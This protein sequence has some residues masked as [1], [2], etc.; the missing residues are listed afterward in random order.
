MPTTLPLARRLGL[1][2]K[3]LRRMVFG[4]AGQGGAGGGWYG[5]LFG[6]A[7]AP[8]SDY[9]YAVQAGDF[10]RNSAVAAC[11]RVIRS[12]VAEP[13]IEVVRD[14]AEGDPNPVA[15]APLVKLLARPNPWYDADVFLGAMFVS[16]I[17]DGNAIALKVRSAAGIPV[18]LWWVPTWTMTPRWP[19][20]DPSVFVSHWEYRPG[21]S[22]VYYEIDPADVIHFRVGDPDDR[23]GGRLSIS[24]LKAAAARSICSL[25][26]ADGFTASILRNGGVPLVA[27]RPTKE[28]MPPS[29]EQ[30]DRMKSDYR[31]LL[32]GEGR[33]DPFIATGPFEIAPLGF[34]PEQL[35]LDRIPARLEDQVCALTGVPAMLVGL[36]SGAQHKTYAN[37][38]EARRSFYEDTLV[39]LQKSF[40]RCLTHQLLSDPGMGD[41]GRER[42]RFN[43][44]GVQCLQE[45]ADRRAARSVSLFAGGVITLA[46]ARRMIGQDADD[47]DE[48]YMVSPGTRLVPAGDLVAATAPTPVPGPGKGP[49]ENPGEGGQPGPNESGGEAEP[50]SDAEEIDDETLAKALRVIDAVDRMI[51]SDAA[52]QVKAKRRTRGRPGDGDEK[53]GKP[54]RGGTGRKPGRAAGNCGTGAGGFKPGNTCGRRRGGRSGADPHATPGRGPLPRIREGTAEQRAGLAAQIRAARRD[55]KT[56]EQHSEIAQRL[57]VMRAVRRGL[58]RPEQRPRGAGMPKPDDAGPAKPRSSPGSKP[59]PKP[60]GG[61]QSRGTPGEYGLTK[62]ATIHVDRGDRKAVDTRAQRIFGRK[63][64]DRE[65]A[66]VAGAPDGAEVRIEPSMH[67]DWLTVRIR[68]EGYAG[69]RDIR[70]DVFDGSPRIYNSTFMVAPEYQGKGIGMQM[71]GRQVETAAKLGVSSIGTHAGKSSLMNGYYTWPRLGYDAPIPSS[72]AGKLP[73]DLAGA[74]MVSDLMTTPRGRDWWKANGTDLDVEFDVRPGSLGRRVLDTYRAERAARD[75]R[76][77]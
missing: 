16:A 20:G 57:R 39:P 63:V 36:T 27:I 51:G 26:E 24:P 41:P 23:A 45:D 30:A 2:F 15:G 64:E 58:P 40:A 7:Y 6:D 71:L 28:G 66:S 55:I 46:D 68:G 72:V 17:V 35:A 8:G 53:P 14:D 67:P 25:N 42:V 60:P 49:G 76:G 52:V 47:E 5:S 37:V 18:E 1:G 31:R 33:G 62:S 11:L 59:A 61:S 75:E 70:K 73:L 48:V 43:Y 65:L 22:G 21:G 50:G 29:K 12:N 9:Q 44:D 56:P 4:F 34:T 10:T 13:T 38:I 3:A 32:T 77:G 19:A 54:R 74:R 69:I